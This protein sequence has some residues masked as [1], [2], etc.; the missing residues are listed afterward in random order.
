MK[1]A[2]SKLAVREMTE[3]R[4]FSIERWG[5]TVALRYFEDLRDAAKALAANPLSATRLGGNLRIRRVR[6]HYLIVDVDAETDTLI[7][8]RVLHTSMDIERHLSN[9]H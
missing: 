3:L 5:S 8:A 9:S 6:S 2:W 7:V 4:R 1:L